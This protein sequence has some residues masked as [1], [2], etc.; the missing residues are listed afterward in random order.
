VTFILRVAILGPIYGQPSAV[1]EV[2]RLATQ[3]ASF[4]MPLSPR[5]TLNVGV[6]SGGTGV[7]VL[8]SSAQFE[9]D[10]R[11]ESAGVLASILPEIEGLIRSARKPGVD[12]TMDVVGERPAGGLPK[13]IV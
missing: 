10:V 3:I 2:A 9:L 5:S 11:S 13:I 6:I 4:Q 1:H 7:N 12:V 8:A